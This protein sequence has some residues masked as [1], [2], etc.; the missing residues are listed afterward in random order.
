MADFESDGAIFLALLLDDDELAGL[1][2]VLEALIHVTL[3][4]R[5]GKFLAGGLELGVA[6]AL[7][8]DAQ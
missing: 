6:P 2:L 7:A 8:G 4:H 5:A 3:D 1:H